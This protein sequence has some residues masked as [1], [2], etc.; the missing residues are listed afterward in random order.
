MSVLPNSRYCDLKVSYVSFFKVS[1]TEYRLVTVESLKSLVMV[2]SEDA[3]AG[4][5]TPLPST[6]SLPPPL[7]C[8]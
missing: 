3:I 4:Y 2:A 7:A 1:Y 5:Y 6:C 8:A